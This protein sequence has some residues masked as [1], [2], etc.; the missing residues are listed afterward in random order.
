MSLFDVK[1]G[2]DTI[3]DLHPNIWNSFLRQVIVRQLPRTAVHTRVIIE[4]IT[5]FRAD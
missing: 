2:H 1:F 3:C 4:L 5:Y